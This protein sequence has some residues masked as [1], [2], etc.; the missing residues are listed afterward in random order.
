MAPSPVVSGHPPSPPP[1]KGS[2]PCE[3]GEEGSE[4]GFG[5]ERGEV[6]PVA[7]NGAGCLFGDENGVDFLDVAGEVKANTFCPSDDTRITMD[8]II[9]EQDP[10]VNEAST[11][12]DDHAFVDEKE[13]RGH[14]PGLRFECNLLCDIDGRF[15]D[16]DDYDYE[17]EW[18][19][20]AAEWSDRNVWMQYC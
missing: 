15:G 10:A 17:A 5:G 11:A 1:R 19:K 8:D 6:P 16:F 7:V 3:K 4:G 12:Y 14:F 20:E 2:P 13:L 18:L 9:Q